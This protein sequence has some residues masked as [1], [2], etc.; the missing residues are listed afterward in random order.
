MAGMTYSDLTSLTWGELNEK[1][2]ALETDSGSTVSCVWNE[3]RIASLESSISELKTMIHTLQTKVNSLPTATYTVP[4]VSQ[5]ATSVWS[6]SS[7]T[8]TNSIPTVAQ[9]QSGL[10]T[11]ASITSLQN[12]GDSNWKTATGFATPEDVKLTTTTQTVDI[13]G[14]ATKTQVQTLQTSVN[15]IPTT[16]YDLS[17]LATKED[18]QITVNA[19]GIDVPTVSE[20][21][22]GLAKSSEIATLATKTQV[23]TLQ[24]SVNAIPTENVDV[25]ELE[26]EIKK[27]FALIANWSVSGT[28]LTAKSANG[29][30]LGTFTLT[31]DS[32]GKIT[33]VT[34]TE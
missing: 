5:I 26:T 4:T 29:S 25:S 18:V 14:L 2:W 13:S 19:D 20:I 32:D 33:S 16:V 10:A 15:A 28:V 17:N 12:H 6:A 11:S 7:R 34:P 30:T 9:I 23:Q 8:V 24:T 3:T 27:V 1:T 31:K 22:S 21:Q